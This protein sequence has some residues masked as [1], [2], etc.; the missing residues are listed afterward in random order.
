MGRMLASSLVVLCKEAELEKSELV[1]DRSVDVAG[2]P[3]ESVNT[4]GSK[5]TLGVSLGGALIGSACCLLPTLA[6]TVGFGGA[7]GLVQLGKY[8][9]Y[10]LAAGLLFVVGSNW[11]LAER[12]K[13][14]CAT[15]NQKRSLYL[16][17]MIS[18]VIFLLAY[19][20]INY[21]LVPWLYGL[22]WGGMP[23]M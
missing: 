3:A 21:L 11:Y 14:C 18:I 10:L 8:Q 23:G 4:A 19:G 9:P 12:D 1:K 5:A 2:A 7:A 15:D 16:R 22:R 20:L 6:L 17:S 13:R